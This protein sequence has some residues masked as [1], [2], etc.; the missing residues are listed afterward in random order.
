MKPLFTA[1]LKLSIFSLLFLTNFLFATNKLTVQDPDIWGTKPGYID[2]ATLVIEPFGGYV[3][4]SLYLTYSD[5]GQFTPGSKLEVVH[6]FELPEGSVI[7]DLWLWIG[8]SV[9]QAVMMDT[10]T[11]RSIYDSIVVI[12][13]DPAFLTK[14]GN[15]YELHIY[16]LLSGQVRR[17]KM[18]FITPTKWFG[19][20]ATAEA[21]IKF[22]QSNNASKKPLEVFFKEVHNIWGEPGIIELPDTKF[23]FYKDTV[24]YRYQLYD[25]EDISSMQSLNVSFKTNF[26]D[27]YY[28]S[29]GIKPNDNSYF[30][31]GISPEQFFDLKRDSTSHKYMIALD[32]SGGHNKDLT[33]LIPNLKKTISSAIGLN[34]YFKLTI[35][36]AGKISDVADTWLPGTE[37]AVNAALSEFSNS[38]LADSINKKS[39]PTIVYCDWDASNG[40]Q[41]PGES[42]FAVIQNYSSIIQAAPHFKYADIIAAY[43]HGFD[44]KIN[45]EQLN[46]ILPPIDSFFVRGGR[47][48]SYYDNNRNDGELLASHYIKGLRSIA[49]THESVKLFR[50]INGNIGSY[51]PETVVHP[52]SY[53]LA[54]NDSSVKVELRDAQ[55]RPAVISKKIGSGL[56]VVSGIWQLNDDGAMKAIMNTPLLGLNKVSRHFQLKQILDTVRTKYE[57]DKFDRVLLFSNSDSLFQTYQADAWVNSYLKGFSQTRPVIHSI[58][59][60]DGE[61]FIPPSITENGVDYYGSGYVTKVLSDSTGGVHFE[62]HTNDWN[63]IASV[64]DPKSAPLNESFTVESTDTTNGR[65]VELREVDPVRNDPNKPLFFIGSS[66]AKDSIVFKISAK[67]E[68]VPEIQSRTISLMFNRDTTGN[69]DIIPA[70]LGNEKL[71]DLFIN[72]SFDTA[73]IVRLA[74]KYNLL[75][76]YTAL[77][78]LEP[79]DTLHFMRNPNDEGGY[80]TDIAK[81]DTAAADSLSLDVYPNPFNTQTAI[82]LNLKSP[83][84]VKLQIFNILGQLV[85]ELDDSPSVSGRLKYIWDGRNAYNESVSSGIYLVR[86]IVKD[87]A[88][89]KITVNMKKIIMLK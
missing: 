2:K 4:Q 86:A 72:S 68:D 10:W 29:G 14:N 67:F 30:Q 60:L 53:F 52:G 48:L 20:T 81:E 70:M 41:F 11:A 78:A 24:G 89:G 31:L 58:N 75:C 50:N 15:Q 62:T 77:L 49:F 23:Q 27:G 22:L 3:E 17:I 38:D 33:T 34:D 88:A 65:L 35:A 54:Y 5:H 16:P 36:G 56:L 26:F 85:R 21:P 57:N 55:G 7:N 19:N 9:M 64:L 39:L 63:Y 59:L 73:Q 40:W 32:L 66:T 80:T 42:D 12:K 46:Y 43:R 69:K 44:D 61:N 76:D 45:T 13:R 1:S 6:R 71:K 28:F 84:S 47:F 79:N 18:T 83:S 74:L 25:V 51:F 37:S 87:K 82:L 8:D